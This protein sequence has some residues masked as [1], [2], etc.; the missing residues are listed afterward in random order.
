MGDRDRENPSS[1]STHHDLIGP[2]PPVLGDGIADH[3]PRGGVDP[4][5]RGDAT[6]SVRVT[7]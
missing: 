4:A 5:D 3:V 7:T 6:T 1:S 2:S